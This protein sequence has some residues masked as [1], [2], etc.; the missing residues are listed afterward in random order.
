M[1]LPLEVYGTYTAGDKPTYAGLNPQ[2]QSEFEIISVD[3][4]VNVQKYPA[5][6]FLDSIGNLH[7]KVIGG[8]CIGYFVIDPYAEI[9]ELCIN[10]IEW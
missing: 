6:E 2:E 7:K 9:S 10:E 8:M 1:G 3:L 4:I 5:Q